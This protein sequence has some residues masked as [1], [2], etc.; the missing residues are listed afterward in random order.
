MFDRLGLSAEGQREQE[1]A[2]LLQPAAGTPESPLQVP[3]VSR[4]GDFL[5]D[6]NRLLQRLDRTP[7]PAT[8]PPAAKE[9]Q[10]D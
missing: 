7:T 3:D 5:G 8:T 6:V 9:G 10:K 2:R 4:I 1:T